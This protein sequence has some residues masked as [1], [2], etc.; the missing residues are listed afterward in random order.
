MLLNL[1]HRNLALDGGRGTRAQIQMLDFLPVLLNPCALLWWSQTILYLCNDECQRITLRLNLS[2]CVNVCHQIHPRLTHLNICRWLEIYKNTKG[3]II[4]LLN[5]L[6]FMCLCLGE[7]CNHHS[8]STPVRVLKSFF[9]LSNSETS[10]SRRAYQ[11]PNISPI[12]P[13][14]SSVSKT[15]PFFSLINS[16]STRGINIQHFG[17]PQILSHYHSFSIVQPQCSYKPSI[18]AFHSLSWVT[19]Y[20]D[21]TSQS[22]NMLAKGLHTET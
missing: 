18:S 8:P 20:S 9:C 14:Y 16:A 22:L 7:K 1:Y 2:L 4:F 19:R 11:S 6:L 17:L 21:K 10:Q 15:I 12:D 3:L 5:L 13:I